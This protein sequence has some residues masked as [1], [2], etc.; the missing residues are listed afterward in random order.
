M[1]NSQFLVTLVNDY[2]DLVSKVE[3]AI[4][5]GMNKARVEKR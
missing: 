1:T 5:N 4:E 3:T 2:P